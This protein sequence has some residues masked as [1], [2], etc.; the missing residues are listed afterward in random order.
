MGASGEKH[1]PPWLPPDVPD[2]RLLK[3]WLSNNNPCVFRQP[4]SSLGEEPEHVSETDQVGLVRSR[5]YSFSYNHSSA[6]ATPLSDAR[7]SAEPLILPTPVM[8][9]TEM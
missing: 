3:P 5:D 2:G 7:P 1:H 8:M 6:A 4:F 9:W